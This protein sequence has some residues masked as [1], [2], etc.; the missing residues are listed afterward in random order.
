MRT[1]RQ[2]FA[3]REF[4]VLFLTQSLT[5]A[6][7]S[8]ASLALGTIT[9]AATGSPV[10]SALSMF[11]GPLLR[12]V[13]SWFLGAVA[14]TIRPRLALMMIAVSAMVADLLQ[15]IPGL[16]W[17]WRFA[18]LA[19]PWL[20]MAAAGG[21]MIALMSDILPRDA[22]VLGRS[23]MNVAVGAMQIV[24]YGL[25]GLLLMRF[26]TTEL[27]LAAAAAGL[28]ALVL[29]RLGL[30][31]HPPRVRVAAV[32]ER[33][34]HV[35]RALLTS[36]VIRPIL[37]NLWVPNGLIVGCE[38]LFVPFSGNRAGY[39]FAASAAGMLM[40]DVVVGRFVPISVRDRLITPLRLLL[41]VPYL[42]FVLVPSLPYAAGLAFVA[43]AGFAASLPLQERLVERTEESARGQVFG[44]SS[45][46][47]L[48]GQAVGA[49]LGGLVAQLLGPDQ[50]DVSRAMGIMAG[51][52]VLTTA[53]LTPGLR[54]SRPL[55]PEP[56]PSPA[57]AR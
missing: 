6:A 35:N 25:G 18:L 11:G 57:R 48:V 3:V 41:G 31:D 34:R 19:I 47:L 52:S 15:A 56:A 55:A 5:M 27:F 42:A 32:V 4:R 14:D 45:T 44:V 8:V 1:Y 46:G 12:L 28:V 53:L 50:A 37:L 10:L 17:G 9:Y 26:T 20:A 29:V 38:A 36:P 2:L 22:F 16:P 51:A 39:L 7:H 23:T 54:R 33:S 43:G 21:S 40:G 30:R 49:L 13:G 24:G